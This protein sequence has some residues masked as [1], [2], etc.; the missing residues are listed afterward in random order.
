MLRLQQREQSKSDL[1]SDMRKTGA[2][3]PTG[4]PRLP[5]L[6]D[7]IINLSNLLSLANN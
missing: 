2:T 1:E 6:S 7:T 5:R 4:N 3:R